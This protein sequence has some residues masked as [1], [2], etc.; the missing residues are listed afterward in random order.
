MARKAN[1]LQQI[2]KFDEAIDTY[3]SALLEH[4]DPKIKYAL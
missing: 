1:S 3:Q 4:N 2:G